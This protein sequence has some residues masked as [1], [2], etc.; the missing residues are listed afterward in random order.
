[1]IN[2][3]KFKE[4]IS[5]N[6][7]YYRKMN[8]LTQSELANKLNYS[9]K[10]ISKWERGENLPDLYILAS[11]AEL[12]GVTLNDLTSSKPSLPKTVKKQNHLMI[13]LLSVGLVWLVATFVCILLYIINPEIPKVWLSFIYAIS[14]S[15][16]VLIVFS[17]IWGSNLLVSIFVSLFVWSIP[18]SIGLS[19]E[20]G[21]LWLLYICMIPL[22]AL[23]IL[24]FLLKNNLIKIKKNKQ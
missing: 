3:I 23:I 24:W 16:I 11:I 22:Q 9:D 21:R 12:Y 18:L 14:I 20:I 4:Q 5:K 2:E 17:S 6:L 1:M 7:I 13:T 19:F 15:F 8:K 10:A